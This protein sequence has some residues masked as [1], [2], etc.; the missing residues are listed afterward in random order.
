MLSKAGEKFWFVGAEIYCKNLS[1]RPTDVGVGIW[2]QLR[3]EDLQSQKNLA[4]HNASMQNWTCLTDCKRLNSLATIMA[5][6]WMGAL[7]VYFLLS[8]AWDNGRK[9]EATISGDLSAM[10][11]Q[12]HQHCP[13]DL[14]H[15]QSQQPYTAKV[16]REIWLTAVHTVSLHTGFMNQLRDVQ[17]FNMWQLLC[18]MLPT[19]FIVGHMA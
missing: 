2:S 7:L 3:T 5:C 4:F 15:S 16:V 13:G 11:I 8:T 12:P 9:P 17:Q 1:C 19:C 6:W 14:Q 10:N 18:K